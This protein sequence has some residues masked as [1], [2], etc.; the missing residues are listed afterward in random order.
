[1][2]AGAALTASSINACVSSA[3]ATP[4]TPMAA[5]QAKTA[6]VKPLIAHLLPHEKVPSRTLQPIR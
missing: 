1:M 3:T 2:D 6:K 4:A 5:P